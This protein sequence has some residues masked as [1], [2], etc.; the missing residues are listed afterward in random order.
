MLKIVLL[1]ILLLLDPLVP[2]VH[3]GAAAALDHHPGLKE[4]ERESGLR[5]PTASGNEV[6]THFLGPRL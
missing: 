1:I 5:L 2:L 6:L 4:S 3:H